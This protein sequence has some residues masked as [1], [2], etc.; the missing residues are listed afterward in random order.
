MQFLDGDPQSG[1]I[2]LVAFRV[3]QHIGE[4]SAGYFLLVVVAFRLR[5]PFGAAG[6]WIE[7]LLEGAHVAVQEKLKFV[8]QLKHS[9]RITETRKKISLWLIGERWKFRIKEFVQCIFIFFVCPHLTKFSQEAAKSD[10]SAEC[11]V[12]FVGKH[13]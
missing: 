4:S 8:F 6:Y 2:F 1:Q 12:I 10:P 3:V 5:F 13:I 9:E 11:G 7:D